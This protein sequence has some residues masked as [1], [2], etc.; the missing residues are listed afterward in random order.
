MAILQCYDQ[1]DFTDLCRGPHVDN[2][3]ALPVTSSL[4]N[5]LVYTGRAIAKNHVMQRIYGVC[6]PTAEELE[7][8]L[9]AS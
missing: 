9:T 3:K 4:L 7:E 5:I 1:G 6:F 8:H 2:A